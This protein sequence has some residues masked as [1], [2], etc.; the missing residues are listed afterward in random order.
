MKV[1]LIL[2]DKI[3]CVH[4]CILQ[5]ADGCLES[6][7]DKDTMLLPVIQALLVK[8]TPLVDGKSTCRQF[9]SW[10]T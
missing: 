7:A 9:C 2:K 3:V 5:V 6:S 10:N 8:G 4:V 1:Y